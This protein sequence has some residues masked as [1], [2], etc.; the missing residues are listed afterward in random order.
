[1]K[2]RLIDILII[3]SNDEMF[4]RLQTD[5]QYFSPYIHRIFRFLHHDDID[6]ALRSSC[7]LIIS[8]NPGDAGIRYFD[9]FYRDYEYNRNKVFGV[10]YTSGHDNEDDFYRKCAFLYERSNHLF[11]GSIYKQYGSLEKLLEIIRNITISCVSYPIIDRRQNDRSTVEIEGSRLF[12]IRN[13]CNICHRLTTSVH[14]FVTALS[15]FNTNKSITQLRRSIAKNKRQEIQT[16]VTFSSI[17][18]V[19]NEL[20]T[21]QNGYHFNNEIMYYMEEVRHFIDKSSLNTNSIEEYINIL[22]DNDI[23]TAISRI[24]QKFNDGFLDE[25]LTHYATFSRNLQNL[26]LLTNTIT[27]KT[28]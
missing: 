10:I 23:E 25:F 20:I 21:L 27:T 12:L 4:N 9:N 3:E 16:T 22:N 18:T 1:M 5:L 17:A 13:M 8:N 28:N 15:D 26:V 6:P 11:L 2:K 19:I 14:P 7:K 24:V